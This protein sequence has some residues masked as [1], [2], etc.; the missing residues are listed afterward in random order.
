MISIDPSDLYFLHPHHKLTVSSDRCSHRHILINSSKLLIFQ[1]VWKVNFICNQKPKKF[2]ASQRLKLIQE[3]GQFIIFILITSWSGKYWGELLKIN[4]IYL[5][6]LGFMILSYCLLFAGLSPNWTVI[7][8][9]ER[10]CWMVSDD[11]SPQLSSARLT[12]E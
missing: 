10:N 5:M 3:V 8:M 4:R 7:M 9:N 12:P 2:S 6:I 1:T 11:T